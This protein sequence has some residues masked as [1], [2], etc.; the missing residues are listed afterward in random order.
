MPKSIQA[1]REERTELARQARNL[2]ENVTEWTE[3]KKAE[4]DGVADKISALDVDIE[5]HQKVLDI[6]ATNLGNLEK[7]AD[8]H[9]ISLDE[10]NARAD[11][12]KNV[13]VAWLRGGREEAQREIQNATLDGLEIAT[14]A[15]GGYTVPDQVASLLLEEMAQIGGMRQAAT[16]LTTATGQT[17]A[18]PTVDETSVKG[19]LLAERTQAAHADPTF[20]TKE[21][22]AYKFSSKSIAV[23]LELLQDT[24]IDLEGFIRRAMVD[25]LTRITEDYYHDGAGTTEPQG[26]VT[27][28]ALGKTGASGQTTTVT[29]ADLVD[30]IHSI[31]PVYRLGGRCG[32]MFNDSTLSAMRKLV[33][34]NGVPLW[35]PNI[36]IG[37][38]SRILG[39]PYYINQEMAD[40]AA[41]AKSIL[42]GDFSKFVIRD[43][44]Q[45]SMMR[46]DDSAYA[47]YGMV[48]FLAMMRSDSGLIAPSNA[49]M[50]YYANAAT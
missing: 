36:T 35:Q 1:L 38:P 44:M 49:C 26:V 48:G 28:A 42:F 23:S 40:M 41:S 5:R 13:F 30:L 24:V 43:T 29:Y 37:E 33:D 16:I 8:K 2:H 6:E 7:R 10:A 14:P 27:A 34:G 12:E 15:D 31:D 25:R 9:G 18:Y 11:A 19:E 46:F 17:I 47:S 39:F 3:E 22:K 20:G 45:V 4:F 50:K 21:I 32:F